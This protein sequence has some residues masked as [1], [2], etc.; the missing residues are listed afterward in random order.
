MALKTL[1]TAGTATITNAIA[2]LQGGLAAADLAALSGAVKDDQ[3]NGNPIVPFA[4]NATGR[5]YIPNRGTILILPGDFVGVDPNGWPILLSRQAA[6]SG[7]W[8]HS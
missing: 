6:A 2:W 7:S 1:G 3:T 4:V 5:L 8:V